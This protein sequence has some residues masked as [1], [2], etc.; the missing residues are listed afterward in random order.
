MFVLTKNQVKLLK[1]LNKKMR[2]V[3][4]YLES[5]IPYAHVLKFINKFEKMGLITIER[6]GN[7]KYISLNERGL[8][9][10]ELII[11]IEKYLKNNKNNYGS[12]KP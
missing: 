12:E 1:L 9:L 5:K 8:K 11:E 4:I 2:I 3:D 6:I 7:Q 10:R